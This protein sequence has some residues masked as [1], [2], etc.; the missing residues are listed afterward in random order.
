MASLDQ[1]AIDAAA[2]IL[3][4]HRTATTRIVELPAHCRPG[5]RSE[6]YAIQAAVAARSGEPI[7]GWKIAATSVAGQQHI[8]VEGP[9]A[10]SLLKNRVLAE[11]G[12][13]AARVPLAGNLMRVVEAEFAFRLGS[14]LPAR[15]SVYG[16]QEVLAAVES[17]HPAVEI[18]DSRF[19]SFAHVGA[20]QLIADSAC[21]CWLVV[22]EATRADWRRQDLAGHRVETFLNG[23]PAASGVGANVLRDPRLALTWLANELRSYEQGLKAGD[24]VT[25]G[26]CI[27][28]VAV[29]PG[30][31]FR[32]DFGVF[33]SLQVDLQ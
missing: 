4:S 12:S 29:A 21:A 17:L 16:M 31:A 32:A 5:D 2:A 24:L 9:I 28:P 22:G 1:H 13:A 10:G 14:P 11:V 27:S 3:W 6:G 19:E 7:V 8:R 18:P 23:K 30:D 20:P 25:T 15:D 26:T 33:G